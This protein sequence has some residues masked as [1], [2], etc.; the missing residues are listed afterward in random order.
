MFERHEGAGQVL[1]ELPVLF[2]LL[3]G[4]RLWRLGARRGSEAPRT[5]HELVHHL[6]WIAHAFKL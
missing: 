2:Y 4:D 6:S 1:G 5:A 3:R